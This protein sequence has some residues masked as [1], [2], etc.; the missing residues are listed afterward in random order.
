MAR[1]FRSGTAKAPQVKPGI[2]RSLTHHQSAESCLRRQLRK[3]L[4]GAHLRRLAE[5]HSSGLE[6]GADG[7]LNPVHALDG[8]FSKQGR[9]ELQNS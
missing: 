5:E 3:Q 4:V 2:C 7:L 6:A 8:D 1:G 9:K